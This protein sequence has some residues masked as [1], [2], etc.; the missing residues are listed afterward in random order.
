MQ[1]L[2]CPFP[3][4]LNIFLKYFLKVLRMFWVFFYSIIELM[5]SIILTE[6][7]A[8]RLVSG[9]NVQY[10]SVRSLPVSVLLWNHRTDAGLSLE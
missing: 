7:R 3:G 10:G 1:T 6:R 8:H 5:D 9:P 4:G 2:R